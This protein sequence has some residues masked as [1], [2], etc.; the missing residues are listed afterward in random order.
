MIRLQ[1]I[2]FLQLLVNGADIDPHDFFPECPWESGLAPRAIFVLLLT[3][4][5]FTVVA[6]FVSARL[7]KNLP[8]DQSFVYAED[9]TGSFERTMRVDQVLRHEAKY[10]SVR[11]EL[12]RCPAWYSSRPIHVLFKVW[13]WDSAAAYTR[14]A[15]ADAGQWRRAS[16]GLGYYPNSF[17]TYRFQIFRLTA[18]PVRIRFIDIHPA[19][20]GCGYLG[21]IPLVTERDTAIDVI[22]DIF[23]LP[24]IETEMDLTRTSIPPRPPMY[25]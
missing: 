3:C 11:D 7:S 8:T 23:H 19:S 4:T 22:T 13:G 1:S 10:F 16:E 6:G 2:I 9:G 21:W 17:N 14:L 5:F 24:R 25:P 20:R 15:K 18:D 12:T